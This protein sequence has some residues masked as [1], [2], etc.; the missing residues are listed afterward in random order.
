[1]RLGCLLEN[2]KNPADA[3]YKPN[4][5]GQNVVPLVVLDLLEDY[6]TEKDV[7]EDD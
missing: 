4:N 7:R 1:M 5:Q 3:D 6:G 2:D